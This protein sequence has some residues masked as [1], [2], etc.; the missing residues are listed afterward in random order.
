M[1]DGFP[2]TA[3]NETDR[4][5]GTEFHAAAIV[6]HSNVVRLL[7]QSPRFEVVNAVDLM[8]NSALCTAAVHG[9]AQML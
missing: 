9:Q 3:V 8:G 5:G 1:R 2:T 6:G 7:L 4:W